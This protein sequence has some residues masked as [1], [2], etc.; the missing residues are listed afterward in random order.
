[1]KKIDFKL[2]LLGLV[3]F[4]MPCSLNGSKKN[5]TIVTSNSSGESVVR[6]QSNTSS[7]PTPMSNIERFKARMMAERGMNKQQLAQQLA[8]QQDRPAQRPPKVPQPQVTAT[9]DWLD[10]DAPNPRGPGAGPFG[11]LPK[12]VQDPR[13]N[14]PAMQPSMPLPPPNMKSQ[15][16][17]HPNLFTEIEALGPT[18]IRFLESG[19]P[20]PDGVTPS[21]E[22]ERLAQ[23]VA[24]ERN[25]GDK[26]EK[27]KYYPGTI[28][29]STGFSQTNISAE[30]RRALENESFDPTFSSGK[31]QDPTENFDYLNEQRRQ[32]EQEVES[33]WTPDRL[34][35]DSDVYK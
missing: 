25:L 30:T 13:K 8:A 23:R 29:T 27:Q 31:F 3:T 24:N 2:V 17:M 4:L 21:P 33:Q 34:Q 14:T 16:I 5:R 11:R 18:N 9:S 7:S 10:L 20:L 1:M 35:F 22:L 15:P 19:I 32:L 12:A 26:T 6:Q 28:P